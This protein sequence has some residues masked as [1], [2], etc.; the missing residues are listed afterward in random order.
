MLLDL[1]QFQNV[2]QNAQ[3]GFTGQH[4]VGNLNTGVKSQTQFNDSPDGSYTQVRNTNN[5]GQM[6]ISG[7]HQF[8]NFTNNGQAQVMARKYLPNGQP[9]LMELEDITL[10]DLAQFQQIQQNADMNFAGTHA[11][12]N[13]NTGAKSNTNFLDNK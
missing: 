5:M 9:V 12:K 8:E 6:G 3:M 1:A 4:M 2:Q 13:I 11:I 10:E 7:N